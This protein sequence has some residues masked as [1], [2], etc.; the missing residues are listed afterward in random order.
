MGRPAT[1]VTPKQGFSVRVLDSD[2][3]DYKIKSKK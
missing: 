3:P 1:T 2:A